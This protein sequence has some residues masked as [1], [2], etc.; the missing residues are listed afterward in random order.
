MAEGIK[1]YLFFWGTPQ[2]DMRAF[3]Y[4]YHSTGNFSPLLRQPLRMVSLSNQKKKKEHEELFLDTDLV[5]REFRNSDADHH[6][7]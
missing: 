7:P 5:C 3:C 4:S 1:K 6:Y 2:K